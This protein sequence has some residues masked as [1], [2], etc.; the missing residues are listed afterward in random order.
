MGS[1]TSM[2]EDRSNRDDLVEPEGVNA[3]A[4]L[5]ER[6]RRPDGT[7]AATDGAQ[8]PPDPTEGADEIVGAPGQ[9]P[10]GPGQQLEVG[11]G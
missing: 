4:T 6:D 10:H 5:G 7:V 3:G 8:L 2:S 1:A 11:E 9:D